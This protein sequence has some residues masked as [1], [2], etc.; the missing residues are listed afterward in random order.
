MKTKKHTLILSA[1]VGAAIATPAFVNAATL[2]AIDDNILL[3]NSAGGAQSTSNF[4]GRAE[5]IVGGAGSTA[6]PRHGIFRFDVSGLATQINAGLDITSATLTLTERM[7]RDGNNGTIS[8]A[9]SAFGI[10]AG[11]AGW[12]EGASDGTVESGASSLRYK[13]SSNTN[14]VSGGQFAFGTDTGAA[15]GSGTVNFATGSQQTLVITLDNAA[16]K[17]LL[18]QWL[19]TDTT[20]AG[21]NAGLAIQSAGTSQLF[22]ESIEGN[23]PDPDNIGG[24]LTPSPAQL[25]ITFVPEPSSAA[26]VGL[27]GLGMLLR[28]RR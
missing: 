14:W 23:D 27:A 12:V 4:G 6:F 2:V 16:M 3:T 22:F 9:F 17:T 10:V 1:L 24:F 11:N 8:Q 28:R 13:A 21:T 26:L 5:M 18:A 7:A 20:T 15:L 19:A 25:D